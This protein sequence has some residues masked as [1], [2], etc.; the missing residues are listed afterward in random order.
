MRSREEACEAARDLSADSEGGE[1][2]RA[3]GAEVLA[4]LRQLAEER[5]RYGS[6]LEDLQGVRGYGVERE[7]GEPEAG[8]GGGDALGF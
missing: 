7:S 8:A 4:D 5:E 3:L 6:E 2:A 1:L